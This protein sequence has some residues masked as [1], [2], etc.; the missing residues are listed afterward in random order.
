MDESSCYRSES[1]QEYLI[2]AAILDAADEAAIREELRTLL[3]PGQIKLHWTDERESR[4]RRIVSAIADLEPMNFIVA[5]LSERQAKTERFRRKCLETLYYELA[6][7]EVY[8]VTLESRGSSQD[9]KDR[10]HIV[11]LQAQGLN[12][13]VRIQHLRGGDEPLLWI[14]D[15]V[16][17]SLNSAY[18]GEPAHFEVLQH[19][20]MLEQHT[21]DSMVHPEEGK[22]KALDPVVRLGF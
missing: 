6:G 15:A 7:A 1:T 20:I 11:A 21:S 10:A 3:L 22:R 17:G 5:H 9:K 13:G 18:L 14:A 16:L 4:R 19:T 8:P 12:K 2:G